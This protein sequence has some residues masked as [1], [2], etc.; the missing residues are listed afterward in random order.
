M[1][2]TSQPPLVWP[3]FAMPEE[4]SDQVDMSDS[5]NP[6]KGGMVSEASGSEA[7]VVKCSFAS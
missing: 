4:A 3:S 2:K 7:A 6:L 5:R 1:S